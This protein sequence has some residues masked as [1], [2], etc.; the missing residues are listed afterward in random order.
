MEIA[1]KIVGHTPI[2]YADSSLEGLATRVR[3][4]INENGKMLCWH[5]TLPEMTHNELV[6]WAGGNDNFVP[7]YLATSYD[8]PRTTHRWNICKEILGKYTSNI[9]EIQA[10]GSSKLEQIFYLIH[11]TDWVSVYISDIKEIDPVEVKVI[12]YL[13]SEMAK[14]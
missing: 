14:K 2:I 11:F 1:Q 4:Q 12:S 10:K 8:H 13:K 5:H 9:L 3:Q 7:I 6:G